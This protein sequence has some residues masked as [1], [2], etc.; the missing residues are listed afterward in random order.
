LAKL[1]DQ[2]DPVSVLYYGDSGT[3]KTTA[4]AH[5]ADL[6]P[7]V[8]VNSEAG[9][10]AKPLRDHGVNVENIEIWPLR[11]S[12]VTVAGLEELHLQLL[13]RL[14]SDP[15]SLAGVVWDSITDIYQV[16]LEDVVAAA[17]E[18]QTAAGKDRDP[19]LID[20]KDYGVMTEQVK[21]LL[22][23]YRDLPC[24]FAVTALS[25]REQDD[26]GAVTY[27]PAA[28]PAL[29]NSLVGWVDVVAHTSVGLRPD[30]EEE[31]MGLF[32]AQGKYR[33]KDRFNALPKRL[34][35]PGF[36][37]LVAYVEGELDVDSDPIMKAAKAARA[38]EA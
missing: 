19:D 32:R 26:D 27:Q 2:K 36:H 21:R 8:V 33:G 29:Q 10:K 23:R 1:T 18:R 28:T 17:V 5:M 12:R 7:V 38:K 11:G 15:D 24:H 16:V 14:H 3:G 31:Y 20:I 13:D 30:G 22:R 4:A 6:G 25:R 37:R 9:L 35:D 34:V